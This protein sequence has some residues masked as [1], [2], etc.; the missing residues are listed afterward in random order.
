DHAHA[1]AIPQFYTQHL[2]DME[3]TAIVESHHELVIQ[4]RGV[5][6]NEVHCSGAPGDAL[7]CQGGEC[8]EWPDDECRDAEYA[9]RKQGIDE[10]NTGDQSNDAGSNF[11]LGPM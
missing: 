3:S 1:H 6:Q 4:L 7:K 9:A 11:R 5:K 8:T 10:R 2:V